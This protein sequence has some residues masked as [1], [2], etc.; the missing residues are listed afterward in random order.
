MGHSSYKYIVHSNPIL[1]INLLMKVL[2]CTN[3]SLYMNF[4]KL[5]EMQ[6]AF[7]LNGKFKCT[8]NFAHMPQK[9]MT[10]VTSIS[11]LKTAR[12][13]E[14]LLFA[15]AKTK[16]QISFMVTAQLISVFVFTT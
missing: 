7:S 6:P 12:R 9:I 8:Q 15:Y 13:R 1:Q 11:P 3:L 10:N 16:A 5:H 2:F 4:C 14:N